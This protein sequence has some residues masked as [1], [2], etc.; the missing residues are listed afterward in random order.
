VRSEAIREVV[1]A[2]STDVEGDATA[3]YLVEVLRDLP[4]QVTRLAFGLPAGSGVMYSDPVTLA[5][6]FSGRREA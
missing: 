1:L 4:V 3:A 6:A 2:L 5:R